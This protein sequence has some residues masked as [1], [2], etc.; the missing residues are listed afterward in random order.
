MGGEIKTTGKV[1]SAK[2]CWWL[3]ICTKAFRI[4]ALDGAAFPQVLKVRY[5]VNGEDRTKRKLL[6]PTRTPLSEETVVKVF[7]QVNNPN[8][9]RIEI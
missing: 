3:K 9:F 5:K 1:V 8:K 4:H 2:T 6:M 7:Y